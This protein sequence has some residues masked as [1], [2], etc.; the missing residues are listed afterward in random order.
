MDVQAGIRVC[1]SHTLKTGYLESRLNLFASVAEETG[2]SLTS[3]KTL[4]TVFFSHK[5]S[6]IITLIP[7]NVPS[8]I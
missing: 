4:R 6:L 2:L 7:I 3:S 5:V 1:C 8:L